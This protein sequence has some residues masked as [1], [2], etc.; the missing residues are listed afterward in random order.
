MV[1]FDGSFVSCFNKN[2]IQEIVEM[3][4]GGVN[5]SFEIWY[6]DKHFMVSFDVN[7]SF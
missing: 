1:S 5:S 3:F 4:P 6:F 7:L 2:I